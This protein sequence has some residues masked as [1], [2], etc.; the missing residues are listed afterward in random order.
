MIC[1]YH[2]WE[3]GFIHHPCVGKLDVEKLVHRVQGP[4]DCKVILQLYSDLQNRKGCSGTC[5]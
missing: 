3:L 2:V 4:G 5:L 1:A